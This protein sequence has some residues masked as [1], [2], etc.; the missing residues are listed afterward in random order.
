[1]TN[2]AP[3][4][5]ASSVPFTAAQ[6][7]PSGA[8]RAE[9][10]KFTGPVSSCLKLPGPLARPGPPPHL[11][12]CSPF[13]SGSSIF[14]LDS[15]TPRWRAER[16]RGQHPTHGAAGAHRPPERPGMAAG[17]GDERGRG[18]RVPAPTPAPAPARA[19]GAQRP[20]P[21]PGSPALPAQP[22]DQVTE[23]LHPRST[24]IYIQIT[25]V[26]AFMSPFKRLAKGGCNPISRSFKGMSAE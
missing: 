16:E 6:R 13:F 21:Q 9:V 26:P 18:R 12:G 3:Q 4:E 20:S 10:S 22:R 14:S 15:S 19:G 23:K 7:S 17:S 24:P 5:N 25:G 2:D 11:P 8:V 1:M